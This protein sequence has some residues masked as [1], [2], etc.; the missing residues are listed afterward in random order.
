MRATVSDSAA[1]TELATRLR[2]VEARLQQT[3]LSVATQAVRAKERYEQAQAQA[4]W[5]KCQ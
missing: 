2:D 4:T 3:V 5:D 1:R